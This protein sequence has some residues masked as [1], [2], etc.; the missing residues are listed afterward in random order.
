MPRKQRTVPVIGSCGFALLAA[1]AFPMVER[2]IRLT[3]VNYSASKS[4]S[5]NAKDADL[6]TRDEAARTLWHEIYAELSEGKPVYL[7]R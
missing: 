4:G 5:A 6:I 1:N 7:G 2:Y 3:S